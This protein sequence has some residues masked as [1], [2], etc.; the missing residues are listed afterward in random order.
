MLAG[1]DH[2]PHTYNREHQAFSKGEPEW[3]AHLADELERLVALHGANT[4]AAVFVEPMAGS[5]GGAA[6]AQGLSAE[7]ARDLR[8]IQ[9]PA[10]VRRGHHRL[11]PARPC[12][13]RRT[14]RRGA[15]HDHL[16]QGRDLGLGADGRRAGAQGHLRG[17]HARA[18]ARGRVLP[19][20]HLFGASARLRRRRSRRSISIAT[21][22]CS[23]ARRSSSRS[24]A[25]PRCRSRACRMCSTSAAS[26]SPSAS[27]SHRSPTESANAAIEA[28]D[29]ASTR[30]G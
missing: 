23:S 1:V 3:G 14:L 28:M 4:I 6:A 8:Q 9:N 10:G 26:A 29:A 20:L 11:R 18:G 22:A 2:L 16:R 30:R 15:G 27:I 7:A 13:R 21:K 17:L 12:L 5:T 24:G 19:R 25:T